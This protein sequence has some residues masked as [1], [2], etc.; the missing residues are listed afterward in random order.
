MVKLGKEYK[1]SITGYSGIAVART[2]YLYGCVRVMLVPT[3]LKDDGDFLPD[4]WFDEPQLASVG[5]ARAKKK[6]SSEGPGGPSRS[7]AP[8]KDPI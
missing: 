2:I 3:K 8:N 1:D 7:V 5:S 4:C 6:K